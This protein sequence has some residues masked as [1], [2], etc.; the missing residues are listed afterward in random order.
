VTGTHDGEVATVEGG[1]D[2]NAKVLG[3]RDQ[4]GVDEANA[5]IC[6]GLDQLDAARVVRQAEVDYVKLA[7]SYET[8]EGCSRSGL[9]GV[10]DLPRALGDDRSRDL[11]L[12][13][14]IAPHARWSASSPSAAASN[15]PVSTATVK[16]PGRL[17]PPSLGRSHGSAVRGH[18]APTDLNLRRPPTG[19]WLRAQAAAQGPTLRSVPRRSGPDGTPR[20]QAAPPRQPASSRS[21][22]PWQG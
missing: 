21:T 5:E 7:A 22:S 20:S 12:P 15:T 18:H 8:Q 3:H 17:G 1:D 19:R 13:A 6:V 4:A 10:L 9:R 16:G 14:S 2:L 11:Q